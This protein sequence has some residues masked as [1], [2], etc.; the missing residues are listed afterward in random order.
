MGSG[1]LPVALPTIARDISISPNLLLWLASI[2]A[3]AAGCTLLAFGSVAD[4]VG[5]K[6]SWLTG[7]GLYIIFMPV[8]GLC[9]TVT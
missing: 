8:C 6:K 9:K 5:G 2:Y 7:P 3:L 1:I 4:V